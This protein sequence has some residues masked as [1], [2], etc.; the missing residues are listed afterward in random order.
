V[1]PKD[2]CVGLVPSWWVPSWRAGWILRALT[3]S[4]DQSIEG[5]MVLLAGGGDQEMGLVGGS[6]SLWVCLAGL[7]LVLSPCSLLSFLAAM[8]CQSPP[9]HTSATMVFGFTSGSQPWAATDET[10]SK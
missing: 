5:W 2:S 10:M 1:P 8:R 4:M 6:G 3:S 9:L 7:N